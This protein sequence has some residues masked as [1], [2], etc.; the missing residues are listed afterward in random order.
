[1]NNETR[2][3]N[4]GGQ[5]IHKLI[6][7]DCLS[8]L[9]KIPNNSVDLICIDPPYL[10]SRQTNFDKGG[11]WNNVN[12]TRHRKTPPKTD[13][14]E[15]DK[16]ELDLITLFK[17]YY[18]VLKLSGTIICFYDIWKIQELRNAAESAKFK[19][20]RLCKWE[21][22]NPVPINSKLNYLT[23]AT[24]YFITAVKG[25]KPT[26]HSEYDKGIYN[27][28]ICSGAERTSHPTQ[29]PLIL[30]EELI[31]KHSNENELVLDCFMGSGTT[32]VA[33]IN[34]N[35]SFIGVE[36]NEEYYNIALKRNAI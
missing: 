31:K 20:L 15:W 5:R 16:T 19:Q 11:A 12:D 26:F 35:R 8:V 21:K 28:A 29:K 25:G 18:R 32:G 10:I 36:L 34:T 14:G 3:L 17:E 13:F 6:Q 4:R 30:I 2:P 1:M 7:D 22:T 9:K 23:N 27:Y 33:C 24:E